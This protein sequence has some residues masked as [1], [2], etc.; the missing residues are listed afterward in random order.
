MA[1]IAAV[2]TTKSA[3][4]LPADAARDQLSY[5]V[6]SILR[7]PVL[8]RRNWTSC[9]GGVVDE[10]A[11]LRHA[12]GKVTAARRRFAVPVLD[13]GGAVIRPQYIPLDLYILG[14]HTKIRIFTSGRR[15]PLTSGQEAT[16]HP[17]L[18]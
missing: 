8:R 15:R 7:P 18:T 10:L 11:C 1:G 17:A 4:A 6:D 13:E 9:L 5:P 3:A 2:V 14:I 16:R 12:R